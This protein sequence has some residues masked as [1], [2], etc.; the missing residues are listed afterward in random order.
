MCNGAG[1]YGLEREEG[2]NVNITGIVPFFQFNCWMVIFLSEGAATVEESFPSFIVGGG[3]LVVVVMV[4][5]MPLYDCLIL[6]FPA[7]FF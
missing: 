6:F 2:A 5:F 1:L 3:V 7:I 4:G